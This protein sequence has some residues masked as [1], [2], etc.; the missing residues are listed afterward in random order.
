MFLISDLHLPL[1]VCRLPIYCISV[2]KRCD[3][4][5]PISYELNYLR[6]FLG[7]PVLFYLWFCRPTLILAQEF[8]L[9]SKDLPSPCIA[10]GLFL[11]L[12]NKNPGCKAPCSRDFLSAFIQHLNRPCQSLPRKGFLYAHPDHAL[13]DILP[14]LSAYTDATSRLRQSGRAVQFR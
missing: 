5:I 7:P 2:Q 9:L 3:T 10:G 14:L 13:S 6:P 8:I 4:C 1:F 12:H 11:L